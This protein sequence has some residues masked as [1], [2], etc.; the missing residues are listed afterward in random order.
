MVS[1][2]GFIGRPNGA[3]DWH[4]VDEEFNKYGEEMLN[5]ADTILFGRV[6]YQLM[7]SYWTT[8]EAKASDPVIAEKMNKLPKIVFSKTLD[9]VEWE[10]SSLVKENIK[11]SMLNLKAQAGKDIIILGSGSIVSIFTQM[12]IIDEYRIIVNPVILGGGKQ[13][14]YGNLNKKLKLTSIKKLNSGVVFLYYQTIQ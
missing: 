11:E 4:L 3:L 2:D 8:V 13:Q 5:S 12:G 9:K 10:N 1:L 7:A 14:F 6:T